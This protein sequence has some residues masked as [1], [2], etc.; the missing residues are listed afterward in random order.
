MNK[1]IKNMTRSKSET[2]FIYERK[3]VDL[4]NNNLYF[5]KELNTNPSSKHSKEVKNPKTSILKKDKSK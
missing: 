5:L 4:I 2:N 3:A 1:M